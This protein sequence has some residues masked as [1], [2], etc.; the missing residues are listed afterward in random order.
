[1]RAVQSNT[2]RPNTNMEEARHVQNQLSCLAVIKISYEDS[3]TMEDRLLSFPV[4][5]NT[6][7]AASD[8]HVIHAHVGESRW[9]TVGR[10]TS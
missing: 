4:S 7:C 2:V 5:E 9:L 3:E 6:V 8:I 1:M 10:Q